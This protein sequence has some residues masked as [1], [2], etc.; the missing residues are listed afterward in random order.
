MIQQSER[1]EGCFGLEVK[2]LKETKKNQLAGDLFPRS[3]ISGPEIR[4]KQTPLVKDKG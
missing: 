4:T 1:N 3:Q 2:P